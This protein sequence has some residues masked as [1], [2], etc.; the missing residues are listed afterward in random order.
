MKTFNKFFILCVTFGLGIMMIQVAN[1]GAQEQKPSA[2]QVKAAFLYNFAKFVEWPE[3]NASHSIILVV[4]GEDPFGESLDDLRGK[5]IRGKELMIK[6]VKSVKNI[7]DC[8]ILF[9][10]TSEKNQIEQIL[11]TIQNSKILTIG[12]A[13]GLGQKGVI[14]NF[15]IEQKRV[16]FEINVDTAKRAGLRFSSNLLKLAKII[17]DSP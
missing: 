2:Y 14:I 10:S 13:E 11:K 3:M 16:R 7:G 17:H 9:I 6:R 4:L 8:Q 1:I 12:D 15:Y 5:M